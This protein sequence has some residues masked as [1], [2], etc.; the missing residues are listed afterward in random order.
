MK[1]G[2]AIGS[3]C[4]LPWVTSMRTTAPAARKPAAVAS[5]PAPS[6]SALRLV[7]IVMS[8]PFMFQSP[9]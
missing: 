1:S 6:A 4:T 5:A 3:G 9:H 2:S 7:G 8:R